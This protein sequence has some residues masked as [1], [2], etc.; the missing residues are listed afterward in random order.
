MKPTIRHSQRPE[1]ARWRRAFTAATAL[2]ALAF[3]VNAAFFELSPANI[4]GLTYGTAA[5]VLLLLVTLYGAR[6][7]SMRLAA[8]MRLGRTRSWLYLHLY[9]GMLFLLLL[10]MHSAFA[11]PSGTVTFWLWI[12]S[13][14]TVVS[15]LAGLA[16]QQWLPRVL[17]SG[18]DIEVLY[19]RIP[20]LVQEIR[21]QAEALV[22]TCTEPVQDLYTR[23]VA[24]ALAGPKRRLSFLLDITGGRSDGL[25]QLEFLKDLLDR[26]EK[27]KLTQLAQL[28]RTK[29]QIDAHYTLQR[30]LR[31]WLYAHVPVSIVVWGLLILHLFS[32][33]YY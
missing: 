33:F 24:P 27:E 9:G 15:G 1:G 13:L 28:Y 19:E 20:Q 11:V 10:L 12:L 8:K 5:A 22:E 4:W 26:E 25:R 29:R 7:R 23:S 31:W 32:V 14:W 2:C 16:L 18:L 17:G 3:L 30:V 21:T 6:R